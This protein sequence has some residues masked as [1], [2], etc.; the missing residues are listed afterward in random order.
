MTIRIGLVGTGSIAKRNYIPCLADQQDVSL[1]Y[2][3]RTQSKAEAVAEEFGGEVFDSLE[4]LIDWS[5]DSV[6]VLTR[7][8]E[9]LAIS[10]DLLSLNP[11][12][13][14]FEKPLVAAAGQENVSEDD[15][16]AARALLHRAAAQQCETAMI[17][18]YRFFDQP[19]PGSPLSRTPTILERPST[20]DGQFFSA[21]FDPKVKQRTAA[22]IERP[23]AVYSLVLSLSTIPD[24][25]PP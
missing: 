17:F 24:R 16:V 8:T 2:F 3:N 22:R 12:R 6:F 20:E 15:F 10:Q 1:G 7:E 4:A 11:R 25:K 9:R 5:P 21:L 14:F 19:M 18:N 13:L 23:D